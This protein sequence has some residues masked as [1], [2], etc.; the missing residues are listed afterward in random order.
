MRMSI[1]AGPPTSRMMTVQ[2]GAEKVTGF[3]ALP[4]DPGRHRDA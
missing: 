3:L 1:R 4:R 2:N